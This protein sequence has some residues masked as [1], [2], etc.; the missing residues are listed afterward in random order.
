MNLT[1][2][3]STSNFAANQELYREFRDHPRI[4]SFISVISEPATSDEC[5]SEMRKT[6]IA[7][8]TH[9]VGILGQNSYIANEPSIVLADI[10][11]ELD[12]CEFIRCFNCIAQSIPTELL[13]VVPH[14]ASAEQKADIFRKWIY[15]PSNQPI[16]DEHVNHLKLSHLRLT[17]V[18]IE[19]FQCRESIYL[20]LSNNR[21]RFLP[22]EICRLGKLIML[23]V[24]N[25]QLSALPESIRELRN[26]KSIHC[27]DNPF[28]QK[29]AGLEDFEELSPCYYYRA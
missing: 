9:C 7:V 21:I 5:A 13:P 3:L 10:E 2:D 18:P 28:S 1:T 19:I 23:S 24:S 17:S 25:N 26:L 15:D 20:N 14:D 12:D 29:P 4:S 11:K 8:R 6:A 16:L 22:E 27:Q